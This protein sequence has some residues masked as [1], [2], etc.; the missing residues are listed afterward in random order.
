MSE[1]RSNIPNLI[2]ADIRFLNSYGHSAMREIHEHFPNLRFIVYGY[3]NDNEYMEYNRDNGV[4]EYLYRPLRRAE[5][6]RCLNTAINHFENASIKRREEVRFEEHYREHL[7]MYRELFLR[8]LLNGRIT[9][10]DEIYKSF[11]YYEMDYESGFT[12]FLVRVDQFKELLPNMYEAEK[13]VISFK[14]AHFIREIAENYRITTATIDLNLVAAII[15][16]YEDL[17]KMIEMCEKIKDEIFKRAAVKVTIGLGRTYDNPSD[18]CISCN[19]A[20]SA[21][22]YRFHQGENMVIPIHYMEPSNNITYRFPSEKESRLVFTAVIGEYNYCKVL[23]QEIFDRLSECGPLPDKFL[24][25]LI[26]SIIIS[27]NRYAIEKGV[28]IQAKFNSFFPSKDVFAIETIDSAFEYLDNTLKSFCSFVLDSHLEKDSQL[29]DKARE[30]CEKRYY[31]SATLPKIAMELGSTPEYINRL[32]I[33]RENKSVPDYITGIRLEEAKALIRNSELNDDMIAVKVG[34]DEGRQLRS[35]FRQYEGINLSD[36]R[37]Q[38][39]SE[40]SLVG[41]RY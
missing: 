1:L 38:H 12:V 6:S 14:I 29:L 10:D 16:G 4:L 9:G 3:Y 36:Y 5:L 7:E 28:P 22:R 35:V 17:D 15:G 24:P 30:I 19:E 26:M 32:F 21:L 8:N 31:E 23:L 41:K 37:T 34:Y 39:R 25:K 11:S 40:N 13:H 27:I 18:I 33:D 20:E 2:I